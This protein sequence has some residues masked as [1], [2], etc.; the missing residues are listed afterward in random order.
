MAVHNGKCIRERSSDLCGN[1]AVSRAIEKLIIRAADRQQIA[2][3]E[4]KFSFPLILRSVENG[5]GKKLHYFFNY[6]KEPI[7]LDY[8][9]GD[10]RSLLDSQN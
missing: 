9:Y 3:T 2:V 5:Y 1:C 6:S 4:R 10:S 7:V 8:P